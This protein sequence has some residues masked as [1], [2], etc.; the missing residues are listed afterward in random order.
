MHARFCA[1]RF[2]SRHRAVGSG[3]FVEGMCFFV[4]WQARQETSEQL[5]KTSPT[6]MVSLAGYSL[7]VG[8]APQN[9]DV[10]WGHVSPGV[11]L[12]SLHR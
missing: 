3:G 7:R 9:R 11:D 2:N 8:G 5:C 10:V 6:G 1:L 4:R 12:R